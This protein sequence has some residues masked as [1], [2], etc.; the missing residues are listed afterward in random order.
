MYLDPS[1]NMSDYLHKV[2]KTATSRIKLL[3]RMRN[4]MSV[5][6]AKSVYSAHILPNILYCS[7]PV[8]KISDTMA[9]QFEKLQE[10]ARKIINNQANESRGNR[11]RSILNQKKL[12]AACLIF[13][14]LRGTSIPAF[15]SYAAEISHNYNTRNNNVMNHCSELKLQENRF[16]FKNLYVTTNFPWRFVPCTLL[17][18][19]DQV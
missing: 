19:L 4:V 1:L 2:L 3:A 7:T 16:S 5:F 6:S 11:F 13:K 15:S 9:Q 14:C 12:K 17:C 18:F 10:K 8:L